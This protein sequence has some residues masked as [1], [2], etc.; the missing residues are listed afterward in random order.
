MH[1]PQKYARFAKE[2]HQLRG[3]KGMLTEAISYGYESFLRQVDFAFQTQPE[4]IMDEEWDV[5]LILDACRV[6]LLEEVADEYD[7]LPE[8]PFETFF[9]AGSY[10]GEWMTQNFTGQKAKEHQVKLRNTS[11][12]TGNPFSEETLTSDIFGELN[13]VWK[14]GWDDEN[15]IM[16]PDVLTDE[17]IS[18]HRS[19]QP[20]Q[21]IVHYMQ[22]HAPFI[23]DTTFEYQTDTTTFTNPDAN[24]DSR[25]PWDLL[26]DG[27]ITK[28][29]LWGAYKDT[30][31]EVLDSV[32]IVLQSIDAENVVISADH[33]NAI[34]EYGLYGHP[35]G[36]HLAPLCEVP[37]VKTTATDTS[38]YTPQ[39][40]IKHTTE[41]NSTTEKLEQ[42]GYI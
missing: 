27:L 31:R 36:I 25:T 10:S 40:Q 6:D 41:D 26:R 17:A 21:M 19:E 35:R 12:I 3:T 33:A 38:E 22:P 28:D 29:E 4:Y 15:G 9:S 34:G 32:E 11:Y 1:S 13:E 2:L 7:F 16:P 18:H 42:L 8:P 14:Y 24:F 5:L 20:D 39:T 30:L 23:S 37:W